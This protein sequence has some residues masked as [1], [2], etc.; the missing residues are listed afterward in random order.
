MPES[1]INIAVKEAQHRWNTAF[2]SRDAA[3][4]AALYTLDG[5]ILPPA[6]A[7]VKGTAAIEE[8]WAGL[9]S[10]G[11]RDHG[12]ETRCPECRG[13]CLFQRQVVGNRFG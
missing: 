13:P 7:A 12:I 8:F 4:I 1:D 3:A 5:T 6:H 2:N 9:V 11:V 10:A